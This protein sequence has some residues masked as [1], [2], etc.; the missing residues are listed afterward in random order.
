MHYEKQ[1]SRRPVKSTAVRSVGYD[2]AEWVLQVKFTN[3]SIY[4]YFRVPP[5]EHAALLKAASIG[6]YI[7]RQVKRYYEYEEVDAVETTS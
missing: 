3:G 6:E 4:N 7:N 2:E 1:I 5:H